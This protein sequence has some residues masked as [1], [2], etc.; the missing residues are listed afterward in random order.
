MLVSPGDPGDSHLSSD[1]PSAAPPPSAASPHPKVHPQGSGSI[2]PSPS[3][4][5]CPYLLPYS[6]AVT[7]AD[8]KQP[9]SKHPSKP[10]HGSPPSSFVHASC[11]IEGKIQ[12]RYNPTACPAIVDREIG[13]PTPPNTI[14]SCTLTSTM[15]KP[16]LVSLNHPAHLQSFESSMQAAIYVWR[17]KHPSSSSALP[18]HTQKPPSPKILKHARLALPAPRCL[19][20]LQSP[21]I[22][23]DRDRSGA[24]GA[25][26]GCCIS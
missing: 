5:F 17:W 24:R 20:F 6:Q 22:S 26:S 12:I 8:N 9:L 15:A 19:P 3:T 14:L 4:L 18:Q 16:F 25:G 23:K 10:Q 7:Q 21:S 11:N 2:S 13:P 1:R